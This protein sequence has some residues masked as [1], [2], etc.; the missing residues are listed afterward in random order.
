[1]QI[2]PHSALMP[3]Y[4]R[5]TPT[6][7]TKYVRTEFREK[8]PAWFAAEVARS[9]GHAKNPAQSGVCAASDLPSAVCIVDGRAAEY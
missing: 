4:L 6:D 1:M 7:E 8:D 5:R 9:N 3:R 2:P